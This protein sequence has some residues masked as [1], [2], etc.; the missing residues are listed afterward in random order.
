MSN[1]IA[2]RRN[3]YAEV[4]LNYSDQV[5]TLSIEQNGSYQRCWLLKQEAIYIQMRNN[6]A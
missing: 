4:R 2:P 6:S 3:C 5:S 1:L